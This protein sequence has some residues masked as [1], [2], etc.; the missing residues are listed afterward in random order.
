MRGQTL[1]SVVFRASRRDAIIRGDDMSPITRP[2]AGEW[3]WRVNAG[4]RG[5]DVE[6]FFHPD[7]E[8]G[9]SRVKRERRA[10]AICAVC[11]V[12]ESCLQWALKAEEPY[13]IWGGLSAEDRCA[14]LQESA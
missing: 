3:D 8:R 14:L 12:V 6:T 13:G 9:R 4:C 5:G 7:N 1:A 11:P 10:K 2:F